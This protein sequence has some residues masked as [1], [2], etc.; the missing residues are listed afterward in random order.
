MATFAGESQKIFV[1]AVFAFHAGK[2]MAQIAAIQIKEHLEHLVPE[3]G[4][5][6]LELQRRRDTKHTSISVKTSVRQKDVAVGIKP[7]EVAK[8]LNCDDRAGDRFLFRHGMLH[9]DLQGFPGTAAE[10]G[11][12]LSIIQ[13]ITA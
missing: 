6:L 10:G 5:Q 2:A 8:G 13:K 11:K 12:K 9:K 3:D 1:A 4:L 7:E